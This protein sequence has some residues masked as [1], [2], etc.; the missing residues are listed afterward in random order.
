MRRQSARV[1]IKKILT[2]E[3]KLDALRKSQPSL[4]WESLD[5]Q[6]VCIL[7]DRTFTGRQVDTT[8]TPMGRVW[9]RCP[10]ERCAGTPRVWIRAGYPL[11]SVEVWQ[12]WT[13][14]IDGNTRAG[15]KTKSQ[16]AGAAYL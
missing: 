11:L 10:T 13:R 7:C 6:R 5:D 14:L 4:A 3:D 9:L 8:V 12:D 2:S 1:P 15:T 16:T